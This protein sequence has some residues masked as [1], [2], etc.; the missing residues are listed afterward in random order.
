MGETAENSTAQNYWF[1]RVGRKLAPTAAH[2][3]DALMA[4]YPH[5]DPAKK[6][7]RMGGAEPARF[8]VSGDRAEVWA[9]IRAA[10]ELPA[11]VSIQPTSAL[12][13]RDWIVRVILVPPPVP[14]LA[15]SVG[16][17][18]ADAAHWRMTVSPDLIAIGGASALL[19]G[20]NMVLVERAR[21]LE[22]R[23]W[24]IDTGTA[25]SDLL[26]HREAVA[27]FRRGLISAEQARARRARLKT[28]QERLASYPG[29]D[30]P[31]LMTLAAHAAS[32]P[33]KGGK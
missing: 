15:A 16:M 10:N 25:V 23:D 14:F 28:S 4:T 6:D 31:L 21:F 27:L 17:S 20:R 24:F 12:R 26:R 13:R 18:G 22:A 33:E 5:A 30:D 2:W 8:L 32:S 1:D 9:P 29:V 7:A 3:K 11:G 19:D